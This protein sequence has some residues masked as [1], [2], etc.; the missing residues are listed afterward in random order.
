MPE[1]E[2]DKR[3]ARTKEEGTPTQ[4]GRGATAGEADNERLEEYLEA[5]LENDYE[6]PGERAA[7]RPRERG[8]E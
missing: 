8:G 3:D 6:P 7:R 1:T 2:R 4:A 5:E